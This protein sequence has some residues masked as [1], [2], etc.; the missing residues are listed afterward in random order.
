MAA[1]RAALGD[2]DYDINRR[3]GGIPQFEADFRQG[4]P[5]PEVITPTLREK[6]QE[7]A[8]PIASQASS[9][10][11]EFSRFIPAVGVINAPL[12]AWFLLAGKL[13]SVSSVLAGAAMSL[14]ACGLLHV[15][16]Q[17]VLPLI[18]AGMSGQHSRSLDRGAVFQFVAL[19]GVKLLALGAVGYA[20][21]NF[22]EVNLP[23]VLIGFTVTQTTIVVV[24]ARH[25]NQHLKI[26]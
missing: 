4:K 5:E 19:V 22:R 15:F 13:W 12:L 17:R 9:A 23:A 16:V 2:I 25:L 18:V 11:P 10:L 14:A 1:R 7:R 21:M 6:T 8:T 26:R 24:I 3:G 20:L